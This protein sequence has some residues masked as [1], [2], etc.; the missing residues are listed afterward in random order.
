LC[1]GFAPV[2]FFQALGAMAAALALV[3]TQAA[4]VTARPIAAAQQPLGQGVED[5]YRARGNSLLWLGPKAGSAAPMLIEMLKSASLDGLDPGDYRADDLDAALRS[6]AGS[7]DRK[8]LLRADQMLSTAFAQYVRDFRRVPELGIIYVDPGL[9]PL[10]PS[11]RVA[12]LDAASAPSL[13]AYIASSGWANPLYG[14]LRRA[15]ATNAF[16]SPRERQLLVLNLE[17]A[18]SLPAGR[19]RYVLVNAAE[20]KLFT[21]EDGEQRDVMRVVVGKPNHPTPMMSAYMRYAALNPYWFVPPDLAA[22]RI[23]PK[24]VRQGLKYLDL[25]GHQVMSD[26]SFNATVLDPSTIDWKAVA[27]G[28]TE[29]RIRQ[30]PGPHNSMGRMKFMFPNEQGI[31]LHDN[32]ER[33]LFAEASRLYSG[34]CVRLEDAPRL[35]QWLFGRPLEWEAAG[36]EE[37]VPLR[38]PV[39][40]YITYL[41]AVPSETG[42][43][44]FDDIYG[45]DASRLAQLGQSDATALKGR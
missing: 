40:V 9:K 39:P 28:K 30:L 32:P 26:W 18:R 16:A 25:L 23:A 3:P 31:Y 38:D 11:P 19:G 33:E 22:E 5:F 29:V 10:P 27:A 6:V 36:S 12:L 1:T 2:H 34:G 8:A 35:A 17:R 15:L 41:T 37:K 45:R 21:Y 7:T 44:Y 24:V 42:I 14:K 43:A 4:A 13:V 20:Q